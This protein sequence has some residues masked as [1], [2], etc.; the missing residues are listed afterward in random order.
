MH[1]KQLL[2]TQKTSDEA[3]LDLRRFSGL[4]CGTRTHGVAR[5]VLLQR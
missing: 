2:L 1:K 4:I 5:C 3:L